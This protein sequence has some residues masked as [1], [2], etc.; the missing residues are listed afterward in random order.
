MNHIFFAIAFCNAKIRRADE[1]VY[2]RQALHVRTHFVYE[3]RAN[4]VEGAVIAS[5]E[6]VKCFRAG[7]NVT[8]IVCGIIAYGNVI[9]ASYHYIVAAIRGVKRRI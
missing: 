5:N 7:G 2:A 8:D 3:M 6:V 4:Y 1:V 9:F